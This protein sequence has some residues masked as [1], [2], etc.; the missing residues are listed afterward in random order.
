MEELKPE[1]YC[2]DRFDLLLDPALNAAIY[3]GR[4]ELASKLKRRIDRAYK[5]GTA[6]HTLLWGHYGGGKTHT[7]YYLVNYIKE[8]GYEAHVFHLPCP[9][10]AKRSVVELYEAI[11]MSFGQKFVFEIL[12]DVW[13]IT[14]PQFQKAGARTDTDKIEIIDKFVDH[15]DLAS[16]ILAYQKPSAEMPYLI[17]KWLSGERC[18]A[19][20]KQS[21]GVITDNSAPMNAI[22]T[23]LSIVITYTK[24]KRLRNEKKLLVLM[25]DELEQLIALGEANDFIELFRRLSEQKTLFAMLLAYTAAAADAVPVLSTAAVRQRFGFPDNYIEVTAFTAAEAKAFV[26][27]LL[28]LLRPKGVNVTEIATEAARTTA[29]TVS[30]DFYPFSAEAIEAMLTKISASG[31]VLCP[32]TI[33]M[34]LTTAIGD[35]LIQEKPSKVIT[36]DLIS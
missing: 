12:E 25:I 23:L 8:S 33:E 13:N 5:T 4:N 7:L 11:T 31:E 22:H 24:I 1:N 18:S 6:M 3:A 15:R 27:E 35:A 29:E 28:A 34:A 20:E 21:L 17:W 19:K 16:V 32:R 26:A 2:L 30:A 10:F 36:S 14:Q 9:S